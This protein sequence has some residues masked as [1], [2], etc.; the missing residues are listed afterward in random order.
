MVSVFIV[1]LGAIILLLAG[2]KGSDPFDAGLFKAFAVLSFLLLLSAEGVFTWLLLRNRETATA[3][4]ASLLK[5]QT[6]AEPG[7]AAERLLAKP[8]PSVTEHTTSTLDS[9]YSEGKSR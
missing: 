7:T 4:A 1:G 5:E 8:A 6:T 2:L 9:L 3:G